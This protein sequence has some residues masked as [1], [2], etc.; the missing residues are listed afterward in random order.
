MQKKYVCLHVFNAHSSDIVRA[1][2]SARLAHGDDHPFGENRWLM[3]KMFH[4]GKYGLSS[5][6]YEKSV[7]LWAI[8]WQQ[9]ISWQPYIIY[10]FQYGKYLLGYGLMIHEY[11]PRWLMNMVCISPYMLV[12][13]H[14]LWLDDIW[15]IMVKN[16]CHNSVD[17]SEDYSPCSEFM[18]IYE[19]FL[20]ID[21]PHF[22]LKTCRT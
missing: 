15:I 8:L 4:L 13:F 22:K 16:N 17:S 3:T 20:I 10:V 18:N 6:I 11:V 2:F 14:H 7:G 9:Y 21:L 5:M 19:Y 1:F 12:I